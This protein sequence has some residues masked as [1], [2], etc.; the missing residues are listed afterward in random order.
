[1][2]IIFCVHVFAYTYTQN[3]FWSLTENDPFWLLSCSQ[4]NLPPLEPSILFELL[5]EHTLF[6]FGF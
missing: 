2:K 5:L 1:M 6:S 4:E 3:P